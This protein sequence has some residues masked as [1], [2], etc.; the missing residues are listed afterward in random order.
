[1]IGDQPD[2]FAAKGSELLC[3][4][5]V[6][7]GLHARCTA[8]AF[9]RGLRRRGDKREQRQKNHKKKEGCKRALVSGQMVPLYSNHTMI[10]WNA[11]AAV[12][13]RA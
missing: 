13:L 3:F 10:F 12:A 4:E 6:E 9:G 2:V 1:V 7:P 8:C 5:N 11:L